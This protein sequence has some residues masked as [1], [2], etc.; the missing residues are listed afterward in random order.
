MRSTESVFL[1]NLLIFTFWLSLSCSILI[2]LWNFNTIYIFSPLLSNRILTNFVFSDLLP[3]LVCLQLPWLSFSG[4]NLRCWMLPNNTMLPH[5]VPTMDPTA[6]LQ[7]WLMSQSLSSL[8]T[9][10][11]NLLTKNKT[12]WFQ[13]IKMFSSSQI[14]GFF[15]YWFLRFDVLN[16]R[17]SRNTI[18]WT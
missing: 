2:K 14:R 10:N 5:L 13:L 17:Q 4:K 9:A 7:L 15:C 16:I 1:Y 12:N 6:A 18:E 8:C 3:I 11:Q